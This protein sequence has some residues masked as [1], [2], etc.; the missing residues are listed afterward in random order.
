MRVLFAGTP[1]VA[2]GSLDALM[3]SRH[4]V[5]GVLTRPPARA[6]RGR[7]ERLSPVHE[8]ALALDVPVITATS[9][10]DPQVL[11]AVRDLDPECCPV[12]AYGALIPP[13][14]LGIPRHGWVNLHFS[15]LPRW[16]GAAPVQ[17]AIREGDAETGATTFRIDAGLDTGPVLAQSRTVIGVHETSGDLLARL[18]VSGAELLVETMDGLEAGS[19]Q[20]VAQ[21]ET[22]VTLAPRIDVDHAR[23]DWSASAQVVDRLVRAMSPAPGAW[24]MLHGIR[25]KIGPVRLRDTGDLAA[26]EIRVHRA[27][28]EVGTGDGDVMLGDVQPHGKRAMPAPDWARGVR[29]ETGER[30]A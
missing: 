29:L 30:F 9:L 2:L 5:V 16:R 8:R 13:A 25:V 3:A 18:A 19:L 22:G 15:L 20:P 28:V 12:V 11:Q 26:G 21:G 27:S 6:G 23:I 7:S 17:Y 4:E 24:T 1:E 10:S 14:A